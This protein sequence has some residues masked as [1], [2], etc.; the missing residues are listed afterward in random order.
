MKKWGCK[1]VDDESI[2]QTIFN[3]LIHLINN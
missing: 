3:Q 1:Q 2:T